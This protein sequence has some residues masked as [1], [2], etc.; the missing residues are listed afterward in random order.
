MAQLPIIKLDLFEITE[1]I[2]KLSKGQ[3][4]QKFEIIDRKLDF[5]FSDPILGQPLANILIKCLKEENFTFFKVL[6]ASA[7]FH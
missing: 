3:R 1:I 4:H 7:R 6:S 2:V 5:E